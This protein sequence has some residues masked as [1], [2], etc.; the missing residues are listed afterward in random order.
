MR[1]M[2]CALA[3]AACTGESGGNRMMIDAPVGTGGIGGSAG[4]AGAIG[5]SGGA[6]GEGCT[7]VCSA[8][9]AATF[10]VT[11]IVRSFVDPSMVAAPTSTSGLVVKIYDP[12]AFVTNPGTPPAAT[13]DVQQVGCFTADGI[14]RFSSGMVAVATDDAPGASVDRYAPIGVS[15]ILQAN[16]NV[17]GLSAF[18]VEQSTLAAWQA[19]IGSTNPPGCSG[20]LLGCGMYLAEYLDVNGCAVANLQPIR[21]NGN[22]SPD[23]V[24]CFGADRLTLTTNDV[25]SNVGICAISPDVVEPHTGA[26]AAGGCTCCGNACAPSFGSGLGGSSSGIIFFQTFVATQ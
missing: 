21:P 4:G 6:G 23:N 15:A 25:T 10:C 12:I 2:I 9:S 14:P 20:G 19:Q 26:C 8:P 13:V 3:A 18:F 22:P 1:W 5:G 11:G 7:T 17:T 16:R 24:F